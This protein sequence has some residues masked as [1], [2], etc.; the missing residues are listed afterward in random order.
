MDEQRRVAIAAVVL[1]TILGLIASL[2]PKAQRPPI[3]PVP[4]RQAEPWMADALP[5]V[6]PLT[7]DRALSAIRAERYDGLPERSRESAKRW[8][9]SEGDR[10]AVGPQQGSSL[11]GKDE[12]GELPVAP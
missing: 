4:N 5:G 2:R 9:T 6:G 12:A 1:L 7:R 3:A 8:F 11:G 10:P